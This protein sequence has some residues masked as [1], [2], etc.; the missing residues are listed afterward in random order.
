[1]GFNPRDVAEKTQKIITAWETL[2]P[3][4]T[5]GG[6]TLNQFKAAVK[7]S[8]DRRDELAS[9]ESQRTIK[10]DERNDADK[11]TLS[12]IELVV[13][14]VKADPDEGSDS[15]FLDALGYV[16]KSERKSGLTKKKA[17]NGT[18]NN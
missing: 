15:E 12:R 3:D 13:N 2:R 7:P 9:L 1:M 11:V 18:G 16:R 17:A 4:S 14:G 6:M 10:I 5:F 8:L